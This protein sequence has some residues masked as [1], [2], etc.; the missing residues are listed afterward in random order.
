VRG[1]FGAP[2]AA[3]LT[4]PRYEYNRRQSQEVP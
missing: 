2:G 4:G 1:A 3:P